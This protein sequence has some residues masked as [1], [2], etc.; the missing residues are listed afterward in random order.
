LTLP[1]P[2]YLR[3]VFSYDP[4]TGIL[5]W[6]AARPKINVGTEAG[7]ST[8]SGYRKVT[9]DG[10][11]Y[12]V[13]RI[14]W[15]MVH[16]EWPRKSI[17]HEDTVKDNNRLANLRQATRSQNSMNR[18]RSRKNTSGHKGVYWHRR[19][20]KWATQIK[21]DGEVKYLGLYEQVEDAVVAVAEARDS[22]H[23]EFARS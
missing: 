3:S 5:T 13:H 4:L 18:S 16:D 22:L 21:L 1:S 8:D 9:L 12:R 23:K 14:A 7:T 6:R 11:S 10:K 15:A 17:D 20:G 2:A 19:A